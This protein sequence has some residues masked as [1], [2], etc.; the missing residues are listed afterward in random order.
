MRTKSPF[1]PTLFLAKIGEG[2]PLADHK[3]NQKN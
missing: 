3:K 1:D 2:R